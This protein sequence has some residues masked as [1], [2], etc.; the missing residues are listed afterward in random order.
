MTESYQK[1]KKG[2][3]IL[4]KQGPLELTRRSYRFIKRK[5]FLNK[6]D[7]INDIEYERNKAKTNAKN[8]ESL[9]YGINI[10]G[11]FSTESG[12]GEMGRSLI[13]S[14]IASKIPLAVNNFT[15]S[16]SRQEDNRYA[17]LYQDSNP[18]GINIIAINSDQLEIF[19]KTKKEE[20]FKNRYNIGYWAW[21]QSSFPEEWRKTFQYLD[22]IWTLSSFGANSISYACR[23]PVIKMP[24]SIEIAQPLKYGRDHFQ[25]PDKKFIFL[26][27][28]DFL[29]VFERKNPLATVKAF[30]N[31]FGDDENVLLVLKFSNSSHNPQSLDKLKDETNYKN[32]M[33]IDKNLTT[34]E[35]H[36]LIGCSDCYISLHR[37]EG[38][39]LTIAEAMLLGKPVIATYYSGNCDFMNG[40][41][42]FP[43][44]Y[45]LVEL[46]QDYYPYKKGTIWAEPDI[47]HAARLMK[48]VYY[49]KNLAKVKGECARK[50]IEQYLSKRTV[51]EIIKKRLEIIRSR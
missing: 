32:I 36:S 16:Y 7:G 24:I 50:D 51:G 37:S 45:R 46:K 33:L 8:T 31:A 28:F 12:V 42:S 19:V 38:F 27:I 1:V 39:G 48:E 6:N 23:I 11:Y 15:Q 3:N 35:V 26:F 29:S 30:K 40:N 2:L 13:R 22:E 41:N 9:P 14:A 34:T 47:E 44:N 25:L 5:I 20:F 10:S 18:Y 4:I 43:V 21:E 49:T 17:D